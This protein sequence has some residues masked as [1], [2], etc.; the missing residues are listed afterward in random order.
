MN[1]KAFFSFRQNRYF[2]I[3]LMAMV[4]VVL[5][6]IFLLQQGLGLYTRHG[7]AIRV[8]D[9]KGMSLTEAGKVFRN[10][11]LRMEVAD[12][13]Y[14]KERPAGCILDQ[15][16]GAGQAVKEERIIYLTINTTNVPTKPLPDVADN[17][18]LRQ[19]R[20]MLD[21]VGF[22]VV[23]IDSVAGERDWV[24]GVKW[25]NREVRAGDKLPVG[26]QLILVVGKGGD[27]AEEQSEEGDDTLPRPSEQAAPDADDS[28]F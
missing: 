11:N 17:S 6:L 5:L 9:V 23:G 20:D 21:N 1:L 16:P 14:V 12:S 15:H 3:N 19:A 24:Y 7:E 8:P 2:W 10:H 25:K 13:V 4:A 18:S 26:A 27:G 28:W 22:K